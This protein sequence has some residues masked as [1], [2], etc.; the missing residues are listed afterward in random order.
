MKTY[1]FIGDF[2][3]GYAK[4]KLNDKWGLIDTEGNEI[5][6]PEYVQVGD[7]HEGLVAVKMK[8]EAHNWGFID[9]TGEVVVPPKYDD[10]ANFYLGYASVYLDGYWGYI[11]T[12]GNEVIPCVFYS[13]DS[14]PLKQDILNLSEEEN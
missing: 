6:R 9:K 12:Q 14:L 3:E 10:V 1:D 13:E 2:S 5:V 8:P 7:F 11:N 4:V